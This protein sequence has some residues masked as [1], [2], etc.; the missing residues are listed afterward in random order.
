MFKK[1]KC[2]CKA[3]NTIVFHWQ[4]C[5][6][7]TFLLPSSSGLL[8]LLITITNQIQRTRTTCL[9]HLP[10]GVLREGQDLT[11]SA[12]ERTQPPGAS[13]AEVRD[14][15]LGRNQRRYSRKESLQDSLTR[16]KLPPQGPMSA[17]WLRG[18]RLGL[19]FFFLF[20]FFWE[21]GGELVGWLE[22]AMKCSTAGITCNA[23]TFIYM[24]GLKKV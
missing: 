20:F 19:S 11:S 16:L 3:C 18:S 22:L 2:T 24:I 13:P 5:K 17:S 8:K 23:T 1:E 7:V 10:A 6:F 9:C 12:F 14:T 21:G 15:R 4:I